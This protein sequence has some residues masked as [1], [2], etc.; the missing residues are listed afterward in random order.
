MFVV[1]F[2]YVQ[3]NFIHS[4]DIVLLAETPATFSLNC[5]ELYLKKNS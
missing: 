2:K 5:Y 1:S 4:H 3:V